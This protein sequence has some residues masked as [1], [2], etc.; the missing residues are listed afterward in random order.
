[1]TANENVATLTRSPRLFIGETINLK[2][3]ETVKPYYDD[4][5]NRSINDSDDLRR[6]LIDRSELES[7][8]SENFAWR[9][10]KMTCDTANEALVQDLNFFIEHIQPAMAAYGNDLDLKAV[11]SPY[12][13]QLT[14][15]GYDVMVRGMKK[16]IELFREENIP[17]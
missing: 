1:M 11:N 2:D 17:L 10:I 14:D 5:L 15:D 4:L 6:W 8:L 16:A 9:Y 12:L 7:Y 13:S 3:W